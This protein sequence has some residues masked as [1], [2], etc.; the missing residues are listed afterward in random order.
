MRLTRSFTWDEMA[1]PCCNECIMDV[2]FMY[3]LQKVRN[4]FSKAMIVTSGY[5]C[6]KHNQ[7]LQGGQDHPKGIAADIKVTDLHDR[8]KLIQ[9]AMRSGFSRIGVYDG[10]IH[11]STRPGK[12]YLWIGKSK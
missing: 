1:C 7:S 2:G 5:R 3:S 6:Q 12:T 4:E 11:L 10:H 8:Y 9:I